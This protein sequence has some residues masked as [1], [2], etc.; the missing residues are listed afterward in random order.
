MPT[1][2]RLSVGKSNRENANPRE[3]RSDLGHESKKT[4]L[5]QKASR[6]DQKSEIPPNPLPWLAEAATKHSTI[7]DV[8]KLDHT[9]RQSVME[10]LARDVSMPPEARASQPL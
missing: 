8:V 9:K 4:T 2:T 6:F 10:W 1:R 7:G 3:I 5:C